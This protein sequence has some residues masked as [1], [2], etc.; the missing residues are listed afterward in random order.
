MKSFL[1]LLIA[2]FTIPSAVNAGVDPEVHKLCKD[3]SDYMGC[4][5][6]NSKKGGLYLFKRE[7]NEI[8]KLTKEQK[9]KWCDYGDYNDVYMRIVN[10]CI[11][12]LESLG[13]KALNNLSIEIHKRCSI[14][15]KVDTYLRCLSNLGQDISNFNKVESALIKRA[16]NPEVF[17]HK[18][19]KYTA[20]RICPAGENMYWRYSKGFMRK[21]KV[22]ELGCMTASQNEAYWREYK[23]REAGAPTGGGGSGT[24]ARMNMETKRIWNNINQ[25]YKN[26]YDRWTEREFGY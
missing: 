11:A 13:P 23:L 8:L 17:T 24:A 5:K 6:A 15:R 10:N 16:K 7:D 3:V 26:R 18:G 14:T 22:E 12:N 19:K 9:I 25:D 4:V 2:A 1:I 21:T 20:S